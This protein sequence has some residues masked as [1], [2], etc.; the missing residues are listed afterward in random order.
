MNWKNLFTPV[1]DLTPRE[2][3]AY[4]DA[5]AS[6]DYQLLDVRQPKEYE[7]GH[8]PGA[9]LI[10]IRELPDRMAELDKARP[11]VVYCAVGGRS[12]AAAQLLAG[13]EFR[14]VYNLSGGI[15]AWEGR[16]ATGPEAAGLELFAGDLEYAD[17]V[18]LAYA[19][20][21]GLQRFYRELA[22]QAAEP[23]HRALYE[24]LAGFEARHKARLEE[25]YRA[26]HGGEAIPAG[27]GAVMEGG[28]Q[29]AELLARVKD[30]LRAPRDILE[31]AMA[32]E[33]QALDLYGRMAQK[34]DTA[35]T[36]DFFL[37]MADEEKEHLGH[38]AREL[39]RLL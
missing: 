6:S 5:R 14:E 29:P 26:G 20:E 27:T 17:A 19:M 2:A 9:R 23:D 3:K 7:A 25:A 15:K 18:A 36:R 37:S 24:R 38:L 4:M 12:R 21:D 32:L 39:D 35:A 13:Q 1:R 34:S 11:L 22:A 28:Q 8:L 10:P 31:L 30:L 33:T 16:Q